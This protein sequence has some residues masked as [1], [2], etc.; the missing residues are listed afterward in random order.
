MRLELLVEATLTCTRGTGRCGGLLTLAPSARAKRL[1]TSVTAP[2]GGRVT[3]NGPCA[4]KTVR[5]QR[6]VVTTGPRY[7]EGKRGRTERLL[8][9]EMKRVCRSARV[10]QVFDIVFTRS[11]AVDIRRSD[12]S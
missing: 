3:C 10:R 11:G 8:R 1:G 6:F 2:A 4:R 12:L 7:G 5:F 9:L